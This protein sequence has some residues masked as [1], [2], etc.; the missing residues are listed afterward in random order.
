M[1]RKSFIKTMAMLPLATCNMKLQ[2]LSK[3]AENAPNT[4][5]MPALFVGHGSPMNA[6]EDNPYTRAMKQLGQTFQKD[7]RKPAAILVV[8]AH[9]LTEGSY[10][11]ISPKPETIHDFGGFPK[12]LFDMQY[13]APGAPET[14]KQ[15][16]SLSNLIQETDSWGLDHGAWTILVHLFPEANIPVFQMSIDYYKPMQYHLDL[17]KQLRNLREKGVLII[18]SGNI[19]HNLRMSMGRFSTGDASPYDWAIEFDQWVGG[20][21]A[22]GNYNALAQY[23]AAGNAGKLSVP[24]PDHYIPM[25]YTL[26]LSEEKEPVTQ[27]YESVEFGGISMRTF[28]VG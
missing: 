16:A 25:L 17:A 4:A 2:D 6:L 15:T 28:Q 26:G 8:S 9:W 12:A 22:A 18:G 24:T 1:D 20:K 21:I 11:S 27:V 14:A 7:G 10:V 5:R 23:E 3:W 13:P 19:V